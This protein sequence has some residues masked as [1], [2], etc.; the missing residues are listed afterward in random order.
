MNFSIVFKNT[1]DSIPFTSIYPS[2][3]EYYVDY[4]DKNNLNSFAIDGDNGRKIQQSIND[5]KTTTADINQWIDKI[6]DRFIPVFT[7]EEY[8]NQHNLNQL[9]A[10]WVNSQY[11]VY[12]V[13]Q[14]RNQHLGNNIVEQVHKIFPDNIQLPTVGTVI[15]QLGLIS[16]Y[17]E[18]NLRVHAL[19]CQFSNLN[20]K[21]DC[22]PWV[23]F[24][25]PFDK[26]ILTNNLANLRLKFTHLGRTLYNKYQTFD[27]DL[28][29]NDENSY[30]EFLG[31]VSLHL[32]PAQ[33]I[34]LSKEYTDWCA[35]HN[36]IP[37]GD[38]L[39]IG[40]IP[41]LKEHLKDYRLVVFRNL[42]Q[43]NSFSINLTERH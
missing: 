26:N 6:I 24:N 33:T 41:N 3:L 35:T 27:T 28:Q 13:Q 37:S 25:N 11:M 14:K 40:N 34:P 12:N 29:Y 8:L 39:N 20:F 7:D 42:L 21:I 17:N 43:Y 9:H 10:D 32:V 30:N 23:Q 18:L 19:E 4:L 22:A 15:S 38:Y 1:G 2:V 5:L 36:K 31:F 16:D